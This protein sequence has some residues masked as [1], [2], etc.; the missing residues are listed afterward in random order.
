MKRLFCCFFLIALL[1]GCSV[2]SVDDY[3]SSTESRGKYSALVSISCE[4][5]VEYDPPARE[6]GKILSAYRVYFDGGA[7]V[8][9]ALKSA[10]KGNKIQLEYDGS[11]SSVYI[12][13][14]DY[15][16]EFN[17]GDL[18]GWQY[19]VNGEFPSE[20]CNSCKISDGDEISWLYTCDLGEDIGNTRR[21]D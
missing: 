9:D 20:G 13:G 3:Y 15:L 18:S 2:K 19:S 5:A 16:Y 1:S 8:F 11:G 7:T 21:V 4:T 6:D 10:C 17:C 12:K 14:I